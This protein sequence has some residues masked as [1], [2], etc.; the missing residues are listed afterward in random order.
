LTPYLIFL[1]IVFSDDFD[2]DADSSD[3]EFHYPG[4]SPV[5]TT[6]PP[7]VRSGTTDYFSRAS[8]SRPTAADLT[9]QLSQ[10]PE[11]R[12]PTH[13]APQKMLTPRWT[14][15]P[16]HAQW[17]RDEAAPACRS[18]QRRFGFLLRRV[19]QAITFAFILLTLML[20]TA[21]KTPSL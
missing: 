13:E 19:S 21:C 1:T 8:S 16:L 9:P 6:R 14:P 18:C 20:F 11:F 7:S 2:P 15:H 17:E 5:E 3:E 10:A 12:V 4:A